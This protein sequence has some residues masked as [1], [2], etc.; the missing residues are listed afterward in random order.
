MDDGGW[1]AGEM[2]PQHMMARTK[3]SAV[4]VIRFCARLPRSQECRIIS[5]QLM[6]AATSVG[7]NLSGSSARP[8]AE[9]VCCQA[10]HRDRGGRRNALLDR[11]TRGAGDAAERQRRHTE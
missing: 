10:R 3:R 9:R 2:T 6:R 7:A 5:R 1:K 4:E 11:V 8:L